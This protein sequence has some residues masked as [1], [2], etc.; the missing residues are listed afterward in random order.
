MMDCYEEEAKKFVPLSCLDVQ[1]KQSIANAVFIDLK[2]AVNKFNE[3][4]VPWYKKM[5]GQGKG[6]SQDVLDSLLKV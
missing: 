6:E 2:A 3:I 4:E 5:V 1:G